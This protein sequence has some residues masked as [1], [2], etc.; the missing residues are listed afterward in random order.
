[1]LVVKAIIG[2]RV[3]NEEEDR[4]MDLTDH[5]EDAYSEV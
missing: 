2:I 5:G 3:D 1:M 4:G